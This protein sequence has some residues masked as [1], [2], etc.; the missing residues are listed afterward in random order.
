MGL[1]CASFPEAVVGLEG[2]ERLD[3]SN[4]DLGAASFY[5]MAN[6]SGH[7]WP[8]AGI[9]SAWHTHGPLC[10]DHPTVCIAVWQPAAAEGMSDLLAT[11]DTTP[12][13]R[14][15]NV[16]ANTQVHLPPPSRSLHRR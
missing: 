7:G 8:E 2:L 6:V 14:L 15:I 5:D 10:V 9:G 12:F 3:L 16:Y 11:S 4:N 13:C 1:R